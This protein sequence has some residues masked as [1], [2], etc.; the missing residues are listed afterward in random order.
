MQEEPKKGWKE[1]VLYISLL[2][3]MCE[4]VKFGLFFKIE[5]CTSQVWEQNITVKENIFWEVEQFEA[6]QCYLDRS[7]YASLAAL[8]C[9]LV[10]AIS[11]VP[12]IL[13]PDYTHTVTRQ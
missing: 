8:F 1:T 5:P 10:L 13:R 7:A 11:L 2:S 6:D 12:S 3:L 9:Y 4:G